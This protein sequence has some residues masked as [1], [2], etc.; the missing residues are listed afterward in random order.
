MITAITPAA[1]EAVEPVETEMKKEVVAMQSHIK[2]L[3]VKLSKFETIEARFASQSQQIE[4]L[5][6]VNKELFAAVELMSNQSVQTPLE[7]EKSYKD[8]TAFEKWKAQ[9]NVN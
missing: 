8:L 5:K 3:E 6:E 1:G 2:T 4:S 9:N 7:K